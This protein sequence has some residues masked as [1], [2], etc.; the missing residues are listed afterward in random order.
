MLIISSILIT[1]AVG[2]NMTPFENIGSVG[3][4]TVT[5]TTV[6]LESK[7]HKMNIYTFVWKAYYKIVNSSLWRDWVDVP[8][9]MRIALPPLCEMCDKGKY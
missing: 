5:T 6:H 7:Q 9:W 4:E 8:G 3:F 1:Y 2:R